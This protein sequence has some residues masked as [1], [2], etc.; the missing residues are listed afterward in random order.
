VNWQTLTALNV[1]AL[2]GTNVTI[3]ESPCLWLEASGVLHV[4]ATAYL[5]TRSTW[6]PFETH[7]TDSTYVNYSAPVQLSGDSSYSVWLS[8]GGLYSTHFYSDGKTNWLMCSKGGVD[9]LLFYS[10][11]ANMTNGYASTETYSSEW[12]GDYMNG[13]LAPVL[14]SPQPA[15]WSLQSVGW[16]GNAN[17]VVY[18][19]TYSYGIIPATMGNF[20]PNANAPPTVTPPLILENASVTLVTNPAMVSALLAMATPAGSNG[21]AVY[22]DVSPAL[23]LPGAGDVL[24][25]WVDIGGASNSPNRFYRIRLGP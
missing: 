17:G 13:S 8:P 2:G 14:N 18:G 16:E 10:T 22:T 19:V 20:G 12:N 11:N 4:F 5:P 15:L 7:S 3:V 6:Y 23:V 24:T 21:A 9:T 1:T 25:N